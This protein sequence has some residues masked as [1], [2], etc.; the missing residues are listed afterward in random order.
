MCLSTQMKAPVTGTCH[1]SVF[2]GKLASTVDTDRHQ[3]SHFPAHRVGAAIKNTYS[4]DEMM[5]SVCLW[6]LCADS[7]VKCRTAILKCDEL[8]RSMTYL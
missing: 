6:H 1:S 5:A 4:D 7:L 3:S 2:R 8:G